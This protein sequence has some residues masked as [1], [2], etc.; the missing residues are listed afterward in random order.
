MP[1]PSLNDTSNQIIS[2]TNTEAN[3]VSNHFQTMLDMIIMHIKAVDGDIY[4]SVLREYKIKKSSAF[5]DINCRIDIHLFNMF[6]QTVYI[7]FNV[8]EIQPRLTGPFLGFTKRLQ[9]SN[10]AQSWSPKVEEKTTIILDVCLLSRVEW[11]H[12]PCDFDI[13]LL[14]ENSMS[15]YI[16]ANYNALSKFV[17]KYNHVINRINNNTFALLDSSPSKTYN[18]I[19]S[20]I[21]RAQ[22]L[23][24]NGWCMD[25]SI[26]GENSWVLNMWISLQMRGSSCRMS[27]SKN[28]LDALLNSNECSLCNETFHPCDIVINT[29]CNH[30]FH[31]SLTVHG[32]T[33]VCK[34]LCEW[35]KRGKLSC[36]LC[37]KDMM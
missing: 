31:W 11:L 34:G 7:H 1:A 9:V 16:R 14:A 25:D 21:D 3:K 4:G 30:N 20:D 18:T 6:L 26:W 12:L 37:R 22:A 36:P 5:K 8:L 15:S 13:N 33:H 19:L 35:V 27:Y 2:Y 17:D 10:K 24:K 29:K 28:K 32:G 23:V